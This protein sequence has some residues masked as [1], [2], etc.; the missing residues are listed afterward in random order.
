MPILRDPRCA[1]HALRRLANHGEMSIIATSLPG[2]PVFGHGR[3]VPDEITDEEFS[4][5]LMA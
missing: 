2:I 1:D 4:Q 5:F 3:P